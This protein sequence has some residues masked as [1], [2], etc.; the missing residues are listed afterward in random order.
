MITLD[1]NSIICILEYCEVPVLGVFSCT[2]RQWSVALSSL[3]NSCAH[4]WRI[5]YFSYYRLQFINPTSLS[6]LNWREK[7]RDSH[8]FLRSSTKIAMSASNLG[9]ISRRAQSSAGI[10]S[11]FSGGIKSD[12]IICFGGVTDNYLHLNSCDVISLSDNWVHKHILPVPVPPL[13]RWLHTITSVGNQVFI[14]GGSIQDQSYLVDPFSLR[15]VVQKNSSQHSIWVEAAPVKLKGQAPSNRAGHTMTV[16]SSDSTFTKCLLF[17]GK[18]RRDRDNNGYLNDVYIAEIR[19]IPSTKPGEEGSGRGLDVI[20][21]HVNCRGMYPRPRHC[22]SAVFLEAKQAVLIFGGWVDEHEFLNDIHLI[23]VVTFSWTS[24]RTEGIPPCPRCQTNVFLVP[25]T[26]I[27]RGEAGFAPSLGYL[28]L[29]GGACHHEV[30]HFKILSI[31]FSLS[32]SCIVRLLLLVI[33]III[34]VNQD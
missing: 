9:T 26:T 32:I 22:H 16:Y 2:C 29:Y 23:D 30:S 11:T 7:M 33:I 19:P 14:F 24:V 5:G 27:N 6:T 21:E 8:L 28:M 3:S 31:Q 13:Q 12:F 15:V 17:G 10:V 1:T 25:P 34:I 18:T 4:L 20:W